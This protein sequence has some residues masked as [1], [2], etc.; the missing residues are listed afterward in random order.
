MPGAL[1]DLV[2]QLLIQGVEVL[3]SLAQ[4]AQIDLAALNGTPPTEAQ[5]QQIAAA[6]AQANAALQAL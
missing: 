3:P 6:L 2:L 4:A 1:V 5:T